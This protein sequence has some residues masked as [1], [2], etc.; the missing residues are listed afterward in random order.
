MLRIFAAW[1]NYCH[2]FC[3][4]IYCTYAYIASTERFSRANG[5]YLYEFGRQRLNDVQNK[6]K[7]G[8]TDSSRL[9]LTGFR[10]TSFAWPIGG[11]SMFELSL[12]LKLAF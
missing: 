6:G 9:L 4:I 3:L 11:M 8:L 1:A 2:T 10:S 12:S 7:T 5:I